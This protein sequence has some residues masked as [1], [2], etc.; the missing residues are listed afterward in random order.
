MISNEITEQRVTVMISKQKWQEVF[1]FSMTDSRASSGLSAM[2]LPDQVK[3]YGRTAH[4][5]QLAAPADREAIG[6]LPTSL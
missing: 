1:S 5:S 4:Y 3:R 2:K 6:R